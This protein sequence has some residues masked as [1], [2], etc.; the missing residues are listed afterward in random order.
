[1]LLSGPG[2]YAAVPLPGP[3]AGTS[4]QARVKIRQVTGKDSFSVILPVADRMVQFVLNGKYPPDIW[5]GLQLVNKQAVTDAP[6]KV[7]G[8]QVNDADP[9][10]LEATVRIEGTNAKISVALD[11]RPFYEW[12]GPTASL[13]LSPAWATTPPGSLALGARANDW[14][15]SEVKAQRLAGGAPT[16]AQTR[17]IETAEPPLVGVRNVRIKANAPMGGRVGPVRAGQSIRVQYVEGRW[18]MSGGV[19]SDPKGWVSPDDDGYP[20]NL[21]GLYAVVDGEA[22][23]LAEV[24]TGTKRRP[25]RYRFDKDC[26]Q[27]ILRIRDDILEDNPGEVTYSVSLSP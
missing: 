12:A 24:P 11:S 7:R 9:H 23:R 18:A 5:S 2:K 26:V 8:R 19:E 22:K 16:P 17:P 20:G 13:S 25:F 15:V 4:Y 14:V 3:F 10:E 21:L 1:M 6:G 27:V